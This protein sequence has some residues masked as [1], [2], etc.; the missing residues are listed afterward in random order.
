LLRIHFTA[1][2]LARTRVAATLGPLAETLLAARLLRHGHP[3]DPFGR[4]R[5]QVRRQL[6]PN[7][8]QLASLFAP[9]PLDLFTLTG[10]ARCLEEG[11][12]VLLAAP[13][14]QL[15]R[16]I[17]YLATR[18]TLPPPAR[19][20][21]DGDRETLLEL[22][23]TLHDLHQAALGAA[24]S[25]TRAYLDAA[26]A[27]HVRVLADGGVGQ[28]LANLH[29]LTRWRPPV[30]EVAASPTHGDSH[31]GGRGLVLIPSLFCWPAPILLHD[32]VDDAAPFL[33]LVPAV[34]DL[35]DVAA[36]WAW[37]NGQ[38]RA[39][40]ALLGRSRAAVLEAVGD[41]CTTTE[42][43]RRAGV[44]LPSASQ[45]AA[46]LRDSGLLVTRRVGCA[47]RHDL[48]GLGVAL[49]DGAWPDRPRPQRR[50]QVLH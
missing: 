18:R 36:A 40:V 14:R 34:R 29:P 38:G 12:D 15:R 33:L 7:S 37:E 22:A 1:Q 24:W 48:T 44:S 6:P 8:S 50:D 9:V 49:L 17:D 2:D 35:T 11:L 20:L 28:L 10:R 46:V 26:V 31:L 42:L 13:R 27:R 4:W 23:A 32:L 25:R 41:G 21:G 3:H 43:A 16:E 47:V 5:K 39:L 19:A 45:H 30:L